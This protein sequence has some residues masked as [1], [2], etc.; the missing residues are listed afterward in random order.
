MS[1]KIIKNF[2]KN[3]SIKNIKNKYLDY[4]KSIAS[5]SNFKKIIFK[6]K[7]S[8]I[9]QITVA[10]SLNLFLLPFVVILFAFNGKSEISADVSIVSGSVLI[11]CQVFLCKCEVILISNFNERTFKEFMGFRIFLSLLFLICFYLISYYFPVLINYNN[12]LLVIIILLS[13]LNEL[14]L[15][16]LETKKMFKSLAIY[17]VIM[18]IIYVVI[19]FSVLSDNPDLTR[20]VYKY[21]VLFYLGFLIYYFNFKEKVLK[22]LSYLRY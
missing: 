3:Y 5:D 12:D 20:T 14:N 17:V 11:L 15:I 4:V 9:T 22:K 2:D 6:T 1:N 8:K 18:I 21:D 7:I 13:W 19:F 16:Y 10:N